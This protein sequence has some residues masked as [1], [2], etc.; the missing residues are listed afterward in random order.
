MNT[1][2]TESTTKDLIIDDLTVAK[3]EMDG[4]I[5]FLKVLLKPTHLSEIE[6]EEYLAKE[7]EIVEGK[8][9]KFLSFLNIPTE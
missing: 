7:I 5:L 2:N 4:D 1:K 8:K 3:Y 9:F 6:T